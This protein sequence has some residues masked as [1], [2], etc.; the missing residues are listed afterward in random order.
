M[1]EKTLEY[2][3]ELSRLELPEEEKADMLEQ[4][5][6]ILDY[7]DLLNSVDTDAT[8]PLI[9][10]EDLRNVFRE[11]EVKPSFDR[12]EEAIV[13]AKTSDEKP[14][15]AYVFDKLDGAYQVPRTVE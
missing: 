2:I 4:M 3:A 10:F 12:E 14:L 7:M 9:Q 1:D 11:D 6:K 15:K 5:Q 13:F 8:E